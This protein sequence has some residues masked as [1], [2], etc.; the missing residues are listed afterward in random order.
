MATNGIGTNGPQD[1]FFKG[2]IKNISEQA[3]SETTDTSSE[4]ADS[5]KEAPVQKLKFLSKQDQKQINES[6]VKLANARGDDL[7]KREVNDE[8]SL[9]GADIKEPSIEDLSQHARAAVEQ[10]RSISDAAVEESQTYKSLFN[11]EE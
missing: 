3:S 5:L 6:A 9:K 4:K 8:W 2:P 11:L 7:L 1:N 10:L